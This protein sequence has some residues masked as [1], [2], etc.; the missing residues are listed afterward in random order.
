MPRRGARKT[1]FRGC[2]EDATG[3]SIV[4]PV[5]GRPKEFRFPK[6]TALAQL[7]KWRGELLEEYG[8]SIYT[9]PRQPQTLR[10][11][12]AEYLALSKHLV[13]LDTVKAHLGAWAQLHGS[14][15]RT[16]ITRKDILAARSKWIALGIK[17]KTINNRVSALRALYRALDGPQRTTPADHLPPIPVHR[18]PA[19][20]VDVQ[21]ILEVDRQLREHERLGWLR[22]A[23]T[24]ARFRVLASTGVRP[25]ELMRAQSLDVDLKRRVWTVRDGKGGFRPGLFLTD[26]MMAAWEL[27][28]AADA[29]G[30]F[31]H[32]SFARRLRKAGWPKGVRPYNLRHSIGIALSEAGIDLSDVQE[33]LGHKHIATTRRHYVPVRASR[34]QRASESLDGRLPWDMDPQHGTNRK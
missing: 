26:D 31:E 11:D 28:I 6:G 7:L 20:S 22:S 5:N 27:F 2:Y 24:R 9:T 34:M 18:T 29:W 15:K 8:S 4:I 12:I 14:K 30:S 1:L 25:S 10:A 23:K 3:I 21:T 16:T 19:I 32:S 33:M 13:G 17:P